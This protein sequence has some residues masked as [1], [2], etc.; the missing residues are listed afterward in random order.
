MLINE[1]L[2]KR[3]HTVLDVF[4]QIASYPTSTSIPW[5][6]PHFQKTV[7]LQ[8]ISDNRKR[9][10]QLTIDKLIIHRR[11]SSPLPSTIG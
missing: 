11:Y 5:I 10:L 9:L 6:D 8:L 1:N 4:F 2:W 7:F 3:T